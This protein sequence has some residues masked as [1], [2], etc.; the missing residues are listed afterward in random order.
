M[1]EFSLDDTNKRILTRKPN[2]MKCPDDSRPSV[3][4]AAAEDPRRWCLRSPPA[5]IR[6]IN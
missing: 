2:Q 1:S 6:S 3:Q 4:D 5:I